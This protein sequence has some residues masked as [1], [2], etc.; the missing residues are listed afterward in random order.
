MRP[1]KNRQL[2]RTGFDPR[3]FS[4]HPLRLPTVPPVTPVTTYYIRNWDRHFETSQSRKCATLSWVALPNKHDGKSFRRLIRMA[5]GPALYGAWV[6]IV[7]VASK[8]PTRGILSDADGP[9]T[10][11]DIAV[12]TD[13]ST[14]LIAEALEVLSS[15]GIGWIG[16]TSD[17]EATPSL[18][19]DSQHAT[20]AL[21]ATGS[22]L[23]THYPTRPD[24]TEQNPTEPDPED[25]AGR[26]GWKRPGIKSLRD[27]SLLMDWLAIEGVK[28]GVPAATPDARI[29]LLAFAERAIEHGRDPPRMFASYVLRDIVGGDD[30]KLEKQHWAAAKQRYA[31][32]EANRGQD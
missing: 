18:P 28:A 23:P 5:N 14:G 1:A 25:S 21:P 16:T 3:R 29:R 24:R 17:A 11:E 4:R 26:V 27:T 7:Q 8:C 6:L 32:W 20:S 9:L 12:K 2:A 10:A 31:A 15:D 22:V 30:S 19:A 13:T